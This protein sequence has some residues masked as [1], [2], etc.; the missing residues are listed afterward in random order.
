MADQR[1]HLLHCLL[2]EFDSGRTAAEAHRNINHVMGQDTISRSTCYN[3]YEKFRSGDR[4]LQD[5]ARPGRPQTF[6]EA[7]LRVLIEADPRLTIRCLAAD[8]KAGI[9]T[10]YRHL[11][12]IGKVLKLGCWI[13]HDLSDFDK[14]RRSDICL[15]LLSRRRNFNWLKDIITGDEKWALYINRSRGRQWVSVDQ[16]PE[17]EPK[18]D[19]HVKKVMLSVWWDT[20][21][22]IYHEFLPH[23]T[24]VTATLYTDQLE[25]LKTK[26]AS[27]RPGREK[28]LFLHDNARPHIAKMTRQKLLELGW[29]ILP[30]PPYSPDIAPSD[31]HLF[32]SLDNHLRGKVFA[33][34]DSL[35]TEITNFFAAK[36]SSFYKAGIEAL[37]E[38]W[39]KIVD[40]DGDYFSD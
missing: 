36:P 16:Q 8:L 19:L 35:K 14:S 25:R 32:R 22:I 10:V 24:T 4:S 3:W 6:D 34:E 12:A 33:N 28:V 26:L 27:V 17:P 23:N 29:E 21:C 39:R 20:Q 31:Y 1:E 30:H 5:E 13:P 11:I 37:P 2:Y 9:S 15:S 18:P 40:T 38:R 7:K